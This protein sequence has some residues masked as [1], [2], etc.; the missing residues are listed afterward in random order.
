MRG[1]DRCCGAFNA[2]IK[3]QFAP[4]CN[5]YCGASVEMLIFGHCRVFIKIIRKRAE[6]VFAPNFFLNPGYKT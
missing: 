4:V 2:I 6:N 3:Q 5:I 1:L